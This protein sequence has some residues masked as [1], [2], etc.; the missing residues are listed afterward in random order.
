MQIKRAREMIAN[1][2]DDPQHYHF[3]FATLAK[4]FVNIKQLLTSLQIHVLYRDVSCIW[5]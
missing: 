2:I 3:H 4:V 5:L 1:M